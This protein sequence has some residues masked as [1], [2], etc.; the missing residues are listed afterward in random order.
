MM[1]CRLKYDIFSQK[2]LVFWIITCYAMKPIIIIYNYYYEY[3]HLI[4]CSFSKNKYKLEDNVILGAVT[5]TS[6]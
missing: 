4:C 6:K 3:Y 2:H 1:V 5:N